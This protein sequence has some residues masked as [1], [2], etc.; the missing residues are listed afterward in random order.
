MIMVRLR[1]LE[2]VRIIRE[3]KLKRIAKRHRFGY[4]ESI[5]LLYFPK[6]SNML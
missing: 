1:L 4:H 2:P 5:Q 6:R 3:I